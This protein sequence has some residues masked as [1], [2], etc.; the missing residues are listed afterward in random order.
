MGR[1]IPNALVLARLVG[2]PPWQAASD[3]ACQSW[4]K[5]RQGSKLKA[6]V[7]RD[8][9]DQAQPLVTL[10]VPREGNPIPGKCN[11]VLLLRHHRTLIQVNYRTPPDPLGLRMGVF[12]RE[13]LVACN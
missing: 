7:A 10:E 3:P 8:A 2:L 11:C 1:T 12:V 13:A 4:S 9:P 5:L 6:A